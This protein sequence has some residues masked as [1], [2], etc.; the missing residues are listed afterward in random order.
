MAG[1]RDH[2]HEHDDD[3]AA[4][5]A[6]RAADPDHGPAIAGRADPRLTHA[7]PGGPGGAEAG[8][9]RLQR[10]A[11]NAAVASMVTPGVQRAVQIDEITS[12][13]DVADNAPATTGGDISGGAVTSDG[14]S[15]TINGGSIH[16]D[17]PFVDAPGLLRVDTIIADNVIGTTYAPG[18]GNLQ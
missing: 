8:L 17:A 16:L 12:S 9:M 6:R 5:V 14:V 7:G 1:A 4:G 18:V 2:R 13:V 15:T 10:T 3:A 11:G